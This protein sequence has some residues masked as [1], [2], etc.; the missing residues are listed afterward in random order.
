MEKD[1]RLKRREKVDA[2]G[3]ITYK[4][5]LVSDDGLLRLTV[6]SK[7]P[8]LLQL[9]KKDLAYQ[10]TILTGGQTTLDQGAH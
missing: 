1:V 7:D 2:G 8:A 3:E 6:K 10:L 9:F 5:G 4:V